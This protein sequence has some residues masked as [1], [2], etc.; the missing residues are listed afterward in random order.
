ML[1]ISGCFGFLVGV[2]VYSGAFCFGFGD[3]GDLLVIWVLIS[4]W[5]LLYWIVCGV[6]CF[7]VI[8]GDYIV[9]FLLYFV[10]LLFDLPFAW[11]CLWVGWVYVL[12]LLCLVC[13]R[14]GLLL[15]DCG[16]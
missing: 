8:V 7:S 4:G 15:I 5:L 11:C 6:L 10:L 13:L 12:L 3:F 16:G 14:D 2:F 9:V 1:M